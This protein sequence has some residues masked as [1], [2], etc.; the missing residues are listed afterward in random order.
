[1]FGIVALG[2]FFMPALR[3]VS[4]RMLSSVLGNVCLIYGKVRRPPI[5]VSTSL[6]YMSGVAS[7]ST[8]ALAAESAVFLYS[9]SVWDFTSP[10]WVGSCLASLTL[11][12]RAARGRRGLCR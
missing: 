12:S 2:F 5:G 3:L 11:I 10:I 4:L 1:M 6:K 7:P 8:T 9:M